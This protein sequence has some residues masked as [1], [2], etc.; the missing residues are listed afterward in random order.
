MGNFLG[1]IFVLFLGFGS[2]SCTQEQ[3]L[4]FPPAPEVLVANCI[5][6]PDSVWRVR[7]TQP[8]SISDTA[9]F[10]APVSGAKVEIWADS[11][12]HQTLVEEQLGIYTADAYPEVGVAY[13]LRVEAEG[14]PLLT[15]ID[16][17]PGTSPHILG[18]GVD[19]SRIVAFF[20][21]GY[22]LNP[23]YYLAEI[24]FQDVEPG[25]SFFRVLGHYYDSA[26]YSIPRPDTSF[27][28]EE[29]KPIY[30]HTSD[31]D[32]NLV[33]QPSQTY[34]LLPDV[35]FPQSTKTLQLY[36]SRFIFFSDPTGGV[37][38]HTDTGEIDPIRN[39]RKFM[40]IHVEVRAM[41]ESYYRFASSYLQQGFNTGDPFAIHNNVYSNVSG[42]KGIFAGFQS[43]W[44]Q[45]L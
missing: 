43:A 17:I 7:L 5:F 38:I 28:Y 30:F 22:S 19:T 16:S 1:R 20:D 14:F 2:L 15:A 36:L 37:A 3:L 26:I 9:N 11:V 12:L 33:S 18:G 29:R 32:V 45:I 25:P 21:A 42:G 34:L 24:S 31:G 23:N 39:P 4:D 40:E 10:G 44:K 35:N 41:S 27:L 6:S 8:R 13:T